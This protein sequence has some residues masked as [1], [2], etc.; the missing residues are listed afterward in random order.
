MV[1]SEAVY[2]DTIWLVIL[3]LLM[4]LREEWTGACGVIKRSVLTF[5]RD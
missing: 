2:K 5:D 1:N 4:G 3:G